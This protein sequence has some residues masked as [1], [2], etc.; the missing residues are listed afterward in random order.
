MELKLSSTFIPTHPGVSEEVW[1]LDLK[2]GNQLTDICN[3]SKDY[4]LTK[5]EEWMEI[6]SIDGSEKHR[7]LKELGFR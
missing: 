4:C 3:G 7:R 1:F 6:L 2:E 5:K